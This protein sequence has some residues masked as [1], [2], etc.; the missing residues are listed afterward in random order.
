MRICSLVP[1]ATEIVAM[2]GLS[3]AL[4]GISHECDYPP[5]VHQVPVMVVPIVDSEAL[6]SAHIDRDVKALVSSGR[7]LYRLNTQALIAARPEVIL[8]QDVCHV[9][10]VTPDQ[11]E[12]AVQLLPSRPKLMTLNPHSLFDVV[13]DVEK[14]GEALGASGRGAPLAE[15][16]LRRI[17]AVRDRSAMRPRPRV[18][19]LE[20]LSPLYLGGHWVPQMVDLA[21]G[22]DVLGRAGE[23]SREVPW[24]EVGT[25]VPDIVVLMPCGFSIERT[26]SELSLL[27][28][29]DK[30]WSRALAS[31]PKTYIVDASSY[32]SRPGPRL[33][34]GLELLA[35]IC[36]GNLSPGYRS[37][38]VQD[39]SRSLS[40]TGL[41]L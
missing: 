22:E 3:D 36:S 16:L 20:W 14:I 31:W 13:K 32:F 11:L 34:D 4:V 41:G 17:T 19:C 26:F 9:C 40:L 33:V 8:T 12:Q 23:P 30:D 6:G 1:G 18:L 7:P 2:L 21:G 24:P 28:R 37:G 10:A 35:D 38:R 39:I 5:T 27:C 29:S 25:A 15:S